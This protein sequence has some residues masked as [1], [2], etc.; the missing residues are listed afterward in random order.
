[1]IHLIIVISLSLV[2][3][4]FEPPGKDPIRRIVRLSRHI[5]TS[6]SEYLPVLSHD[7]AKLYFTAMDRTG[8]FDFK[9][10]FI[11]QRNAG[12]E[13]IYVS[14]IKDGLWQDAR[15]VQILNTNRH[16][17]VTQVLRDGSLML[18]ANYDEK[19]GPRGNPRLVETTDLF[20][21]RK[22][23]EQYQINHLP[24]PVNSIFNE[25]DGWMGPNGSF[26]LFVSDRGGGVGAYKQK[27]WKWRESF[28]GNTDVY[29]ALSVDGEWAQVVNLGRK[30]NTTGAERTP[31]MSK[32]GLTLFISS[33]G[34]AGDRVDLDVYRFT[35]RTTSTWTEWEGPFPV[36]DVNSPKDDWGY[37]QTDDGAAYF[38]R[39]RS[40]SFTRTQPGVNGDG[41]VKEINFR[42]GYELFGA[43]LASLS[44]Q[45]DT[46]IFLIHPSTQPSVRLTDILFKS[47]SSTLDETAFPVMD[48]LVE[49]CRLN[50]GRRILITGHTDDQ[51]SASYNLDLSKRRAASVAEYLRLNGVKQEMDIEGRGSSSPLMPNINNANRRINRRVEVTFL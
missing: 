39:A 3:V 22:R 37:K 26:L 41:G 8:F 29:V 49:L 20:F 50:E 13:D 51:G 33:N 6:A 7:G 24:E 42:T 27:G 45:E 15:P 19:L 46:D 30:V 40:L 2:L 14:E 1:M 44:A 5:N 12:G 32:D 28:W 4:H 21:A 38:A 18:T 9:M 11:K 10:D 31:W 16:E 17:A 34:H 35:R 48:R 36:S 25:A 43:Q 23:G 47:G